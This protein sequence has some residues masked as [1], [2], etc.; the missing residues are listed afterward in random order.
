[1]RRTQRPTLEE[2]E[3]NHEVVERC[4]EVAGEHFLGDAIEMGHTRVDQ[5]TFALIR[6]LSSEVVALR[7]EVEHLRLWGNLPREP[8]S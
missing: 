3:R 1:M 5:V 7:K 2:L 4:V 6:D 8:L